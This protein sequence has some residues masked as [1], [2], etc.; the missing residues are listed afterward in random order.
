VSG[1]DIDRKVGQRICYWPKIW[2]S[3]PT[4]TS[5]S[6]VLVHIIDST[7]RYLQGTLVVRLTDKPRQVM[8]DKEFKSYRAQHL[9]KQS[10]DHMHNEMKVIQSFLELLSIFLPI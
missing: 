9:Q 8:V 3:R 4:E 10:Y 7:P 6:K 1:K 5:V 2:T